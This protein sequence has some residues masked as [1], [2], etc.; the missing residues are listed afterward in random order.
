MKPVSMGFSFWFLILAQM[1]D[2]PLN[3]NELYI[4]YHKEGRETSQEKSLALPK[5]PNFRF[6]IGSPNT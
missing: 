5:L 2:N 3:K 6:F 4:V 1:E